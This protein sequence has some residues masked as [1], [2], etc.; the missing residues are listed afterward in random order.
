[1][2]Q[3][4]A[5]TG[6]TRVLG[7]L[8]SCY[9]D[10]GYQILGVAP[11]GRAAR[12]LGEAIGTRAF[13]LHAIIRA[14]ERTGE[15]LP[16]TMVL[17]DEAGMAPT[18]ES[19]VLFEA[20]ERAG[21]KLVAAGDVG[22][23]PSVEA[24]GWFATLT[25]EL[26]GSELRHVM[27]QRNPSEVAALEALHDGDADTYLGF[28]KHQGTL[29]V[30]AG[31]HDALA[32]TLDAWDRARQVHGVGSAVM[33][34]PDNVTRAALNAQARATLIDAGV[35]SADA[36]RAGGREFRVGDRVITRRN[37][38]RHDVD[39]GTL[40]VVREI[41]PI[42]GAL[43]VETDANGRRELDLDYV[44]EHVEHAYAL[45]GHATQGASV[46]WAA[47]VGRPN[48]FSAEWAYTALSRARECTEFYVVAEPS[49]SQRDRESY[50]P[51]E[52]RL[53]LEEALKAIGRGLRRRIAQP[54]AFEYVRERG[55]GP[56]GLPTGPPT[57]SPE[58]CAE[59][60][61][62]QAVR[63]SCG[64]PATEPPSPE[65]DWRKL[66]KLRRSRE[67]SRHLQR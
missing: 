18:R 66:G 9:R 29:H 55:S 30:H 15:L 42:T 20:A 51:S 48:D 11:T 22:Q 50:S 16:R 45:T 53:A 5:G 17:L 62:D 65:P 59:G 13:T 54:L 21:A 31:E 49:A 27:R 36:V 33:I 60:L 37:D 24:G 56:V 25:R 32:A 1:M 64:D 12:E 23:L 26:R 8:A 44:S 58:P 6:K 46:A 4:L 39:N 19:A 34:A 63:R 7:A 41:H 61:R 40:A 38:R 35:L 14:L 3:A 67:S 43:S 47:V 28:K 52:S 57:V 10:A 2:L